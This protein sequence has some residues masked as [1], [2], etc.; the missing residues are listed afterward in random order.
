MKKIICKN[1]IRFPY[2]KE[3]NFRGKEEYTPDEKDIK[4]LKYLHE[5]SRIGLTELGQKLGLSKDTIDYRIKKLIKLGII[6][7]FIITRYLI[8]N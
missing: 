1:K 8:N 4:L 2:D 6:K 7:S 3:L 5:D